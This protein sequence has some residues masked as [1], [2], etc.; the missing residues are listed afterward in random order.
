MLILIESPLVRFI[1]HDV[2]GGIKRRPIRLVD[3]AD[4]YTAGRRLRV[5]HGRA[6]LPDQFIIRSQTIIGTLT[7]WWRFQPWRGQVVWPVD[8]LERHGDGRHL[9]RPFIVHSL[10]VNAV[11]HRADARGPPFAPR[12]AVL[13]GEHGLRRKRP[14]DA[15]PQVAATPA[16]AAERRRQIGIEREERLHGII[17]VDVDGAQP[18]GCLAQQ[19]GDSPRTVELPEVFIVPHLL[20]GGLLPCIPA[21]AFDALFARQEHHV[22]T[23]QGNEVLGN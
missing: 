12:A 19:H 5:I 11:D 13:P 17:V 6:I 3:L 18:A 8:G 15:D 4:I 2:F 7:L 1:K 10:G 23:K 16:T 22:V 20:D 21:C 14:L 9:G